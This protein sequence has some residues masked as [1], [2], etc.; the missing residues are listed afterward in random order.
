MA[1]GHVSHAVP[2]KKHHHE[3]NANGTFAA[4]CPAVTAITEILNNSRLLGPSNPALLKRPPA[5]LIVK[6]TTTKSEGHRESLIGWGGMALN[7]KICK[8]KE[9]KPQKYG[10]LLLERCCWTLIHLWRAS[11]S[12]FSIGNGGQPYFLVVSTNVQSLEKDQ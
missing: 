9:E 11:D 6:A 4:F 2:H 12:S 3:S 10:N 7:L 1:H 8:S 5:D